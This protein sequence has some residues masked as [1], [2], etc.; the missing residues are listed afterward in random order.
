M[1]SGWSVDY[2]KYDN[3]INQSK[4][5]LQRYT[6][7]RD[8]LNKTGCPISYSLCNGGR[9]NV[10]TW[11]ST[12]GNSWRITFDIKDNWDSMIQ[13][14]D[15]NDKLANDSGPGGWNDPDMLHGGGE[16]RNELHGVHHSF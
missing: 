4:P 10:A 2:L 8:A 9:E 15:L 5:S 11:G 14:A 16:W 1:V 7:M 13:R 6:A 3:C 12:V